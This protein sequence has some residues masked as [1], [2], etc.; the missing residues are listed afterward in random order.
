MNAYM[1]LASTKVI[2]AF[3]LSTTFVAASAIAQSP[4]AAPAVAP[5]ANPTQSQPRQPSVQDQIQ[6]TG[7]QSD[8]GVEL[9]VRM[10]WAEVLEV[11]PNPKVVTDAGMLA[12]IQ[13]TGLPWKVRD[14]SC[15]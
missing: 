11:A 4:A 8:A 2:L 10:A 3:L 7:G 12:S 6:R 9:A 5:N 13:A 15:S 1:N 14:P